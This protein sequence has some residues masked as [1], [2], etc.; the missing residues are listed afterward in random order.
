METCFNEH[1]IC[2]SIFCPWLFHYALSYKYGVDIMEN[3]EGEFLKL[4]KEHN[5]LQRERNKLLEKIYA[6]LDNIYGGMM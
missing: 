4:L 2:I 1:S 3:A 5:E 6:T